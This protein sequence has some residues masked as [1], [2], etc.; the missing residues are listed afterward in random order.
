M[1]EEIKENLLQDLRAIPQNTFQNWKKRWERCINSRGEYFE[2]EKSDYV[3]STEK[4]KK[5]KV[6]YLFGL[7]SY[8]TYY[9]C[10]ILMDL[11]FLDRFSKNTQL[12]NFTKIHPLGAELF[13]MDG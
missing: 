6:R 12:S 13:H 8:S 2:G 5:K 1:V 11:N 3:V 7:P 9:S 4:N 10:R